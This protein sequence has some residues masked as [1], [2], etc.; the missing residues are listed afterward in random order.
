M[1]FEPID[2]SELSIGQPA[3]W[4]LYDSDRRLLLARG[5]VIE[6]ERQIEQLAERGLFRKLN[7]RDE[8]S[9]NEG[10]SDGTTAHR[11]EF[12]TLDEIKL[13]I[14]DSLHLQSQAES[15]SVRYTVKLIGYLRGKGL[16]VT[17]PTQDGNVLLMRDGLSFVVRLFSGKSVYAFPASIFKVAN[18]PYPHLH[19][20]WPKQVKGLVIR[21]GARADVSLIAATSDSNG[22]AGAAKL[23][24]LS[25][26]GCSLFS[27]KRL[28]NPDDKIRIKFRVM[29]SDFEQYLDLEGTIRS[30]RV[31]TNVATAQQMHH[32]I[33]FTDLPSNDRVVLTA[34]VYHALFEE[35]AES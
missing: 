31:D 34:Y 29:V 15:S 5:V 9:K 18:V 11:E 4:S 27:T 26:G 13:G 6:S 30:V 17:T 7:I 21:R 24:T 3:P 20:T 12:R 16:I 35:A 1:T 8:G 14:G 25:T 23:D 33:Q 32:G 10:R 19:L 22:G 2:K 28:G